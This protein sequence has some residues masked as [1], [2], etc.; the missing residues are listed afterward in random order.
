MTGVVGSPENQFEAELRKPVTAMLITAVG[1]AGTEGRTPAARAALAARTAFLVG[2][3]AAAGAAGFETETDAANA[4]GR[5]PDPVR[6]RATAGFRLAT[7]RGWVFGGA[8]F[9]VDSATRAR[10]RRVSAPRSRDTAP[11]G[12][13]ASWPTARAG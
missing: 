1:S 7:A 6:A 13:S 10:S 3:D 11:A 2:P 5:L 4:G 9:E 12:L 8:E